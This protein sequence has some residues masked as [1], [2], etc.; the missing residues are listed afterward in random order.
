M[1]VFLNLK[2]S[3]KLNRVVQSL[4]LSI[5]L[6]TSAAALAQVQFSIHIGPPEPIYEN[7][8]TLAPGYV[9]APGYWAWSHDR[10]VWIRGRAMLGRA[11]YNWE[12][13]HW[14]QRGDSYYRQPGN[15]TRNPQL[16]QPRVPQA[17]RDQ[18]AQKPKNNPR[19]RPPGRGPWDE[20]QGNNRR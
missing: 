16:Q 9:W 5:T 12:P 2:V 8:P 20:D 14:Q 6:A 13:D 19:Q 7:H 17:Q 10:H 4:L 11:G 18:R 1:A 15:W 3:M